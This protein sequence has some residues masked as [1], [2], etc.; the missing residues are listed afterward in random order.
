MESQTESPTEFQGVVQAGT[1][2]T[3]GV[4]RMV[5]LSMRRGDQVSQPHPTITVWIY[6]ISQNAMWI[7]AVIL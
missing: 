2:G 3:I 1:D 7:L 5:C 6:K 4:C